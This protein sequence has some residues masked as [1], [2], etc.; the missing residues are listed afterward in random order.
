MRH[1]IWYSSIWTDP[2]RPYQPGDENNHG[3]D[4]RW[5]PVVFSSYEGAFEWGLKRTRAF[6]GEKRNDAP[7]E[8]SYRRRA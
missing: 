6:E 1:T 7:S 4:G 2:P 8:A 3:H 5:T